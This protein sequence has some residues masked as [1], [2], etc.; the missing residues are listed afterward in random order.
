M[1]SVV[2]RMLEKSGLSAARDR[3]GEGAGEPRCV[4]V[5]VLAWRRNLRLGLELEQ[6]RVEW[7]VARAHAQLLGENEL[8]C[9]AADV[10]AVC[11]DRVEEAIR[12]A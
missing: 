4:R 3:Y 6:D 11:F 10:F 1:S 8:R 9:L 2:G 5:L 7:A 12:E